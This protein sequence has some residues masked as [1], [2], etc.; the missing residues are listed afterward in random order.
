MISDKGVR[1]SLGESV[2]R[3]KQASDTGTICT[4]IEQVVQGTGITRNSPSCDA[5][6][7]CLSTPKQA[8]MR[9]VLLNMIQALS[10]YNIKQLLLQYPDNI[11]PDGV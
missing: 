10:V 9:A 3:V 7:T 2:P 8:S 5:D 1:E 4:S 11:L 6:G